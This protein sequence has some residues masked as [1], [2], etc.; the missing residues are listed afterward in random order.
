[1]V[2]RSTLALSASIAGAVIV[3]LDGTAL[4]MAQPSL[5]RDFHVGVGAVQWTSTAYLV[6]VASLL[7]VSATGSATVGC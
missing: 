1:M 3:A 2:R 6:A 5:Q 7:I 4:T